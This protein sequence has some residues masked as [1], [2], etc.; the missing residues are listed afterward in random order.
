MNSNPCLSVIVPNFNN[1]IYLAECLDSILQAILKDLEIVICDDGSIDGSAAVI[2]Q[3]QE[4]NPDVIKSIF[5]PVNRGVAHTRHQAVMAARGEYLTTLD[6]DDYYCNPLKLEKEFALI[7]RFKLTEGKDVI[8]FSN[9]LLIRDR[10]PDCVW[11]SSENIREGFI[12]HDILCRTCF[13][14]ATSC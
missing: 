2:R 3:Y 13:I 12:G 5:N 7:R 6:S 9:V 14:P 4:R 8:S 1:E 11:G 10:K